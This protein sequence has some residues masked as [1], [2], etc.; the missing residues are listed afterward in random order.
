[1]RWGRFF[2]LQ[3]EGQL[4]SAYISSETPMVIYLNLHVAMEQLREEAGKNNPP[5]VGPKVV[6]G[7]FIFNTS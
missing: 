2:V 1:M 7:H 3:L 5:S 4:E 6:E